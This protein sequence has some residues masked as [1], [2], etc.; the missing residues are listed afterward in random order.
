V[1][2]TNGTD[3]GQAGPPAEPQPILTGLTEAA[4]FVVLTVDAGSEEAVRDLL[5]DVGGLTRSVGF[6]IPAGGLACVVGLGSNLWDRVFGETRPAGLHQFR[7]IAGSR[8]T[9]VATPGDL[10]FHIRAHRLDSCFELA[11]LLVKRLQGHAQVIE[12]VHG[13]K[14]FDER[15]LLG[16]VDG[17]ENPTGR[18]A[19]AAA[20]IGDEDPDFT[21]G[22]YVIIQKYV[23]DLG[24]WDQ[25]SVEQQELVIGRTKLNDVELSDDVKPSDSHV[26]LNTI[27]DEDGEE[28]QIVR[29]NM[30]FGRVGTR[31]FGTFYI[32]YARTPDV[33]ERM[34]R[35]MFVGNPPGNTDRILEF[36]TPLTGNLYFVPSADFID[37]PPSPDSGSP[38]IAETVAGSATRDGSLGIG[39]L[40]GVSK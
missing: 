18:G 36:S 40:K 2:R 13:F 28:R 11:N 5:A 17:T 35:N 20:V 9:A 32:A 21:G 12:E 33:I 4:I 31:E 19:F 25:L 16:F 22:S 10:L 3:G 7:E 26:A 34:L 24:A 1:D 23:H 29:F 6:R 37:D 27:V 38:Q 8:H 30:P 14:Y 15:D 39:S